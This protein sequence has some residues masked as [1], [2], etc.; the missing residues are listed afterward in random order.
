MLNLKIKQ[1]RKLTIEGIKPSISLWEEIGKDLTRVKIGGN[2]MIDNFI[3]F[4]T[5][6]HFGW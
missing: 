5:T 1:Q 2:K 6:G 3:S 4:Y